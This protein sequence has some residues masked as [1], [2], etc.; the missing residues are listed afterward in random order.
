MERKKYNASWLLAPKLF[1]F[2]LLISDYIYDSLKVTLIYHAGMVI[3][4]YRPALAIRISDKKIE[5]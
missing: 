1:H 4:H 5:T 2:Y 3:V